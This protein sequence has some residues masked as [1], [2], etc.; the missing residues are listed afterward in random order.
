MPDRLGVDH[1]P[2]QNPHL[3]FTRNPRSPPGHFC[4]AGSVARTPCPAG[5]Y[6]A[7]SGLQTAACSGACP[8]CPSGSIATITC[9][10]SPSMT[11][12][13]TPSLS[14][15]ASGTAT[16]SPSQTPTRTPSQT[17]TPTPTKSPTLSGT[18]SA[19]GSQSRSRPRSPSSSSTRSQT[20]SSVPTPSTSITSSQAA[21]A[22]KTQA[23]TVL[24]F[25][26]CLSWSYQGC[27]TDS[28]SH[29]MPTLAFS[30]AYATVPESE[31]YA[32]ANCYDTVGLENGGQCFASNHHTRRSAPRVAVGHWVS[33][34]PF[35]YTRVQRG[36]RRH[37]PRQPHHCHPRALP[38]TGPPP[39]S[40][41]AGHGAALRVGVCE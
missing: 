15:S 17:S 23:A 3:D 7:S 34:L 13:R 20:G 39:P 12:T 24:P 27:W 37:Q 21:S 9:S 4:P 10:Q 36:H 28:V 35:K 30:G 22:S 41:R 40:L 31:A 11:Q 19:T 6:G 26:P 14:Q 25:L 18:H 1:A 32:G 5:T 29:V 33:P 38:R 8:C 2:P 16:G